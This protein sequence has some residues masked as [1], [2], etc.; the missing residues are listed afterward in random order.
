MGDDFE[1]AFSIT[2]GL[3]HWASLRTGH[4]EGVKSNIWDSP[5]SPGPLKDLRNWL[6]R[7]SMTYRLAVHGPALGAIKEAGRFSQAS[8]SENP[9]V[10]TLEVPDQ[11]I[12]EAFRPTGIAA[13]LDQ[14]RPQ[15][16]E[17]MRI[18]FHLL[19][20]MDQCLP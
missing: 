7:E 16:R 1:N 4:Y 18:T 6:S 19:K 14:S 11:K 17:G 8:R 13:R 15:V 5:G 20:A 2:Y 3:D 12:R 10:T 9:S